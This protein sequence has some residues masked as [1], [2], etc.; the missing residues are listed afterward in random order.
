[1][2]TAKDPTTRSRSI[3]KRYPRPTL[4]TKL[5]DLDETTGEFRAENVSR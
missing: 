3:A 2:I 1:M 4:V 5:T